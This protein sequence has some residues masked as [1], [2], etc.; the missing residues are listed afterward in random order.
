MIRLRQ[1]WDEKG[2]DEAEREALARQSMD[3]AARLLQSDGWAEIVTALT[4]QIEASTK[5]LV[6]SSK[7]DEYNRGVIR[8]LQHVLEMPENL[9][10]AASL[11]LDQHG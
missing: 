4:S 7:D 8:A 5:D 2:L 3:L 11:E 9:T 1:P 10:R 6:R